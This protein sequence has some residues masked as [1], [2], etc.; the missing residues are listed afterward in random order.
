VIPTSIEIEKIN[1]GL[2]SGDKGRIVSALDRL[3]DHLRKEGGDPTVIDALNELLED[4]LDI[5]RKASWALGKAAQVKVGSECSIGPLTSLLDDEDEEVRENAAWA[6]GELAG[7]G[8]GSS[9]SVPLL[10]ALLGDENIQVRSMS[11]WTLGRLAERAG[12][13]P[14]GTKEAVT[15][16][17]EDN[18]QLVRKSA[19][20]ALER[21]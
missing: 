9:G 19:S 4:D 17:L 8:K 18:S 5:R 14:P 6:L 1:A 12:I 21:M 16:L 20:W 13:N 7:M 15:V 2:L 3:E 11:A 10:I